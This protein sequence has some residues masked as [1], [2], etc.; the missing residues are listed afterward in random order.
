MLKRFVYLDTD[1]INS[2]LAQVFDG[3]PKFNETEVTDSTQTGN[4]I[5]KS[6]TTHKI[7]YSLGIPA[8]LGFKHGINADTVKQID[9]VTQTSAGRE[10][11]SKVLDDNGHDLFVDHLIKQELMVLNSTPDTTGSYFQITDSLELSNISYIYDVLT[12]VSYLTYLKNEFISD[13]IARH[14]GSVKQNKVEAEAK[15]YVDSQVS[16]YNNLRLLDLVFPHD[17]FIVYKDYIIFFKEQF[18]RESYK[19]LKY[20]YTGLSTLVGVVTGVLSE[21]EFIGNHLITESEI[22]LQEVFEVAL[23]T[24]SPEKSFKVITPISWYF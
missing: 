17:N 19:S 7:E 20:G 11:L 6:K 12:S 23:K 3:L 18:L 5:E 21:K 9:I 8:L 10:L 15:K 2:S 4:N 24:L 1:I 14:P 13:Y 16:Q 22:A